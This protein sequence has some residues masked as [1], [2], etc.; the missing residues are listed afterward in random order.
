MANATVNTMVRA[1]GNEICPGAGNHPSHKIKRGADAM[2]VQAGTMK[3]K[4]IIVTP[5]AGGIAQTYCMD[6]YA[7][8]V[9]SQR[10]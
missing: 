4:S 1:T 2:S 10:K 5:V 3:K 7:A 9:A 8:L 6:G